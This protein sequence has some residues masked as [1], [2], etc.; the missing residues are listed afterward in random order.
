MTGESQPRL[1]WIEEPPTAR[2]RLVERL[3][4][5]ALTVG[6]LSGVL[7]LLLA[8]VAVAFDVR[9]VVFQSGSMSPAIETGALGIA[10]TVP[11]SELATGDVVTVQTAAG[12][13]VTHRIQNLTIDAQDRAILVLKG[14]ANGAPDETPYVVSSAPRIVADVPQLGYVAAFLSGTPGTFLGGLLVGIVLLVAVRGDRSRPGRRRFLGTDAAGAPHRTGAR[15]TAVAVGAVATLAAVGL[16]S[17][18]T[19]QAYYSDTARLTSGTFARQAA[20]PVAPTIATCTRSGGD[21]TITWN[22]V[23][24]ATSYTVSWTNPVGTAST[25]ATSFTPNANFNI[26][27]A[28]G[29]ISVRSVNAAGTSAPSGAFRYTGNGNNAPCT[30]L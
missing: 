25:T 24:G 13:N 16:P 15:A 27:G 20:A 29:Q 23:A 2:E 4:E 11:A 17:T 18:P 6:A 28:T 19:T 7:C 5:G 10:R 14:D 8:A 3:R 21:I 30:R 12:V 9:P 1:L 26:G 22:A